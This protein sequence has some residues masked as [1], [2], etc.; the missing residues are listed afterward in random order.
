MSSAPANPAPT[1]TA[2]GA[3]R[4]RTN[5]WSAYAT[6]NGRIFK[7]S[8][9]AFILFKIDKSIPQSGEHAQ[10]VVCSAS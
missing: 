7:D 5:N 3:W 9:D 1:R 10:A 2:T 4:V 8:L 6:H